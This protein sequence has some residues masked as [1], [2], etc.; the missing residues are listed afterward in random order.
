MVLAIRWYAKL[1]TS[2]PHKKHKKPVETV[3]S[4]RC[5][6]TPRHWGL[7]LSCKQQC[8]R[9]S[10]KA[11]KKRGS[12]PVASNNP[13]SGYHDHHPSIQ[14]ESV[15]VSNRGTPLNGRDDRGE[16]CM[17]GPRMVARDMTQHTSA[18]TSVPPEAPA[19]ALP[20]LPAAA[21]TH[22][23]GQ[24]HGMTRQVQ[25]MTRQVQGMNQQVYGMTQQ[26][27]GM[28]RQNQGMT[29]QVQGMAQQVPGMAQQNQGMTQQVLGMSASRAVMVGVV[30]GLP[31]GGVGGGVGVGVGWQEPPP[32]PVQVD[33]L[34]DDASALFT[35]FGSPAADPYFG[36]PARKDQPA[37]PVTL[38]HLG[39]TVT[40]LPAHA[41]GHGHPQHRIHVSCIQDTKPQL[42]ASGVIVDPTGGAMEI[43]YGAGCGMPQPPVAVGVGSAGGVGLGP[44]VGGVGGVF[45]AVEKSPSDEIFDSLMEFGVGEHFGRRFQD[46][47]IV[48]RAAGVFSK[49]SVPDPAAL[50]LAIECRLR[51]MPAA[52]FF[53]LGAA[54]RGPG[55]GYLESLVN[56][57]LDKA[58][59]EV[60]IRPLPPN[61]ADGAAGGV[62]VV[63]SLIVIAV[64]GEPASAGRADQRQY[65]DANVHPQALLARVFAACRPNRMRAPSDHSH[66]Q[67]AA[68]T[69]RAHAV[70]ALS[71][72]APPHTGIAIPLEVLLAG[73][74]PDIRVPSIEK[75]SAARFTD[76]LLW[77][78]N[79]V[80]SAPLSAPAAGS[81]LQ[82][83][84]HI[85]DLLA[86]RLVQMVFHAAPAPLNWDF[87]DVMRLLNLLQL[88]HASPFMAR[89]GGVR[90]V[91]ELTNEDQHDR[92]ICR[93]AVIILEQVIEPYLT[94][95]GKS[96][97]A[98]PGMPAD[99]AAG[100]GAALSGDRGSHGGGHGDRDGRTAM[101]RHASGHLSRDC[102]AID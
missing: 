26:V 64:K 100:T 21:T 66:N 73:L 46:G 22:H 34:D 6:C 33:R 87:A 41:H 102:R 55:P 9:A 23:P 52:D 43:D 65:L 57:V 15:A 37:D 56:I 20:S 72:Y 101:M 96:V 94:P 89:V 28:T 88:G 71:V 81:T 8:K 54:W 16:S 14:P 74:L 12:P 97:Q 70:A 62:I 75:T 90:L 7:C 93:K 79:R 77:L 32:L 13:G 48:Y 58:N 10:S 99:G 3:V 51:A 27:Q 82:P 63:V 47:C 95:D 59:T 98:A 42:S 1:G 84:L 4:D 36:G 2:G 67:P 80:V 49:A 76:T 45:S 19:T 24:V 29:Q 78:W 53:R 11:S 31:F 18:G 92:F 38:L 85:L 83:A 44:A 5:P 30:P 35:F 61:P 39:T 60:S 69:L 17:A 86:E 91:A 50:A 40:T 25:G 68:A